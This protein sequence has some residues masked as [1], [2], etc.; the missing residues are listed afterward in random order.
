MKFL[1]K[2]ISKKNSV[3]KN[4]SDLYKS[5]N[6][7]FSNQL[8]LKHIK[9]ISEL[10]NIGEDEIIFFYKKN[11]FCSNEFYNSRNVR[12]KYKLYRSFFSFFSGIFFLFFLF[13]KSS[14]KNPK[15]IKIDLLVDS[16]DSNSDLSYYETILS[17]F[18]KSKILIRKTN[19]TVNH[20]L[21]N[22]VYFKRYEN[23]IIDFNQIKICF[24]L[25]NSAIF[26][27]IKSN[28]NFVF[29]F[30]K[31]INE[32]YY[33]NTFFRNYSPKFMLMH[34]H[35]ATSNIKNFIFKKNGGL[36]SAAIQ[37]N[38]Q[39]Q[40]VNGFFID[41]DLLFTFSKNTI[42]NNNSSYSNIRNFCP[43]GSFM[44]EKNYYKENNNLIE[45]FDIMYMGAHDLVRKR[46]D[47]FN[48]YDSYV[49]DYNEQINWLRRFS[50]KFENIKIGFKYHISYNGSNYEKNILKNTNINFVDHKLNS[51]NL[52]RN[53]KII[54]SWNSTMSIEATAINKPAFFLD[55]K[56][57]N[58]VFMD[59]LEDSHQL[60][61]KSYQDFEKK[62]L[63]YLRN[64]NKKNYSNHFC[65]NSEFYSSK[66][67]DYLKKFNDKI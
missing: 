58:K 16:I 59:C 54:C 34:Q 50:L 61:I 49:D 4:N 48:L 43:L 33:F 6:L 24:R 29:L 66:L 11:I 39:T 7:F 10:I 36:I 44:M 12:N 13:F 2:S 18:K 19:K 35:Y 41:C 65:C 60:R 14:K 31:L 23:Y 51:Y 57:R 30:L 38:I 64:T 67:V 63:Y 37:K 47:I 1:F 56:G 22:S 46:N 53:S 28:F 3:K 45:K 21:I 52:M 27:S 42:I 26:L 5:I 17:K 8:F 25:L 32:Y 55:P 62:M 15:T 9:K 20:N 40:G